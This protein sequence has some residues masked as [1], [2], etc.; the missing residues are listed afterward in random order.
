[1][2]STENK[3]VAGKIICQIIYICRN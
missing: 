1:V 3:S 2:E